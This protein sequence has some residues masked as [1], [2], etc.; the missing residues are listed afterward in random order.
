M[1]VLILGSRATDDAFDLVKEYPPLTLLDCYTDSALVSATDPRP[2]RDVAV[3][4]I[5]QVADRRAVHRDITGAVLS[6]LTVAAYDLL[7]YDPIDER[8]EV[9]VSSAGA[10]ATRSDAFVASG[11]DSSD[12]HVVSA[13]SDEAFELWKRGWANLIAALD[14]VDARSRLRVNRVWWA[15][16][17]EAGDVPPVDPEE[18]AR[19]NA[20]LV[21]LYEEMAKSIEPWQFLWFNQDEL[22]ASRD[23]LGGSSPLRYTADC[24]R[25]VLRQLLASAPREPEPGWADIRNEVSAGVYGFFWTDE[26]RR[27]NSLTVQYEPLQPILLVEFASRLGAEFCFDIGANVGFYS[28]AMSL[29]PEL[30]AVYAFEADE[31]AYE[32][33]RRNV[34]LNGLRDLV[35]VENKAVSVASGQVNFQIESALSG[36]NSIAGTSMH[37]DALFTRTRAVACC[38]LDDYAMMS[39]KRIALKIDVE[40]HETQV[41]TGARR[42]LTENECLIQ[43]EIYPGMTKHMFKFLEELGYEKIFHV[44]HDYY[45]TNSKL[46]TD[47][48]TRLDVVEVA[49]EDMIDLAFGNWP[50]GRLRHAL[51]V[52]AQRVADHLLVSC[53]ADP[54]LFEEELEYAFYVGAGQ[55]RIATVWYTADPKLDYEIPA[56]HRDGGLVVT[57]FVREKANPEKKVSRVVRLSPL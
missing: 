26:S 21:R 34:E 37:A 36:I 52:K 22:V 54:S 7:V 23:D 40:G 9:I 6:Q 16:R 3:D 49:M 33:L 1:K 25:E 50:T 35:T 41:I 8:H 39:G 14:Q 29:I 10:Y 48:P 47:A 53:A 57:A 11:Y 17:T 31:S 24:S 18:I 13:F 42:L 56:V 5:A 44:K 15:S 46:L 4:D 27:R 19:A 55:Q 2:F 28:V 12:D 30:R 43:V 20:H 45:F 32:H 51:E 38:A